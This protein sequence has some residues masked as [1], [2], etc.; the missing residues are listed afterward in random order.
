MDHLMEIPDYYTRLNKMEKE[1]GVEEVDEMKNGEHD[2]ELT[3]ELLG[4]KPHNVGDYANDDIDSPIPASPEQEKNY[5]D[6]EYYKQDQGTGEEEIIDEEEGFEEYQ[7]E[8][9]D[10]YQ[11]GEGNQF[12]V[13]DKVK[14]GVTLQG[15]GGES[16]I[17]TSDIKYLKKL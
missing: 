9:G 13:R 6:A 17:A 2:E 8:I 1:A 15:Q 4:F 12:T 3:D 11:D 16:E 14:G 10:R 5:W 7:G